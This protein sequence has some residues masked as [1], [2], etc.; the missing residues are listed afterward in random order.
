MVLYKFSQEPLPCLPNPLCL[1]L[2]SFLLDPSMS[3]LLSGT[4]P[5]FSPISPSPFPDASPLPLPA[6]AA[7]VAG[8]SDAIDFSS[9][10]DCSIHF[11][12]LGPAPDLR[13]G[14]MMTELIMCTASPEG[15]QP[16][17]LSIP[18]PNKTVKVNMIHKLCRA[19]QRAV[20]LDLLISIFTMPSTGP[21][22]KSVLMFAEIK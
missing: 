18:R 3:P 4:V 20:V 9:I 6:P 15:L 22:T 8:C 1:A 7:G 11:L 12:H 16:H 13:V 10:K 19:K 14:P 2:L 21:G 5:W 17:S